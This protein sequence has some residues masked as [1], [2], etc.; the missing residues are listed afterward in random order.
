[1]G[2]GD[3]ESE[4]LNLT[5]L[6]VSLFVQ[7]TRIDYVNWPSNGLLG[8]KGQKPLYPVAPLLL[9]EGIY[10]TFYVVT[11]GAIQ[12]LL[13]QLPGKIILQKHQKRLYTYI[14]Y[15]DIEAITLEINLG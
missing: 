14:S 8:Y 2:M 7:S 3:K 10:T 6:F 15:G 9:N 5:A 11:D 4:L 13:S 1:M 12:N